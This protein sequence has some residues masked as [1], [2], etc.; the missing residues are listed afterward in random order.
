MLKFRYMKAGQKL[1]TAEFVVFS[2]C[3]KYCVFHLNVLLEVEEEMYF[4][5]EL[6]L[7]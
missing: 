5:T 3:N 1:L 6:D 7:L 4:W 2:A